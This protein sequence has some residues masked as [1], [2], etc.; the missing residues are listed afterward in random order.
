MVHTL[1]LCALRAAGS[2]A[3]TSAP[4]ARL[5]I[6]PPSRISAKGFA[7]PIPD[8]IADFPTSPSPHFL[9]DGGADGAGDSTSG[10][11]TSGA[12]HVASHVGTNFASKAS[13][14]PPTYSTSVVSVVQ[15]ARVARGSAGR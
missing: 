1:R 15:P 12:A 10:G 3:S 8:T 7:C 9:A 13:A 11:G 14:S 2:K 4:P 6:N 5:V